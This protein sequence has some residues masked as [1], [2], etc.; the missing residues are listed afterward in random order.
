MY[1]LY[2]YAS[3]QDGSVAS[4]VCVQCKIYFTYI[5][6]I[7][8][9]WMALIHRV[10][11]LKHSCVCHGCMRYAHTH[12]H[13]SLPKHTHI[14]K[15]L[16][17]TFQHRAGR[18]LRLD[19][20]PS[21]PSHTHTHPYLNTHIVTWHISTSCRVLSPTWLEALFS[22]P[23]TNISQSAVDCISCALDPRCVGWS[24]ADCI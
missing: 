22:F 14:H 11:K 3:L 9:A 2:K 18:S 19:W 16:P 24:A 12:T 7:Y 5:Y 17:D 15:S 23:C 4:E 21:F 13:K 8:M 20:R 10:W 6:F 1:A